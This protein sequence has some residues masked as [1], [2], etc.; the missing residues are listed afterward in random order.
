[1]MHVRSDGDVTVFERD[2]ES[3]IRFRIPMDVD[4]DTTWRL[5]SRVMDGIVCAEERLIRIDRLVG[6][7]KTGWQPVAAEIDPDI[8]ERTLLHAHF[9]FD[10]I[11]HPD[12]PGFYS[13]PTKLLGHDERGFVEPTGTILW[14]DARRQWAVCSDGFWWTP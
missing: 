11:A 7:V 3:A 13:P 4:G 14:I 1:M 10:A 5:L 8:A 9:A 6:R 12:E 2:R